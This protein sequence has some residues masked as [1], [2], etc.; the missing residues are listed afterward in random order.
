MKRQ[1]ITTFEQAEQYLNDTPKFTSKHTI[2]ETKEFLEKMG[3]PD[4]NM[5]IIHIAGTNGKGSTS[6]YLDSVLREAGLSTAL[7]TSP[8]LVDICERFCVNGKMM[9]HEEFLESFNH[10]Y[11]ML[12]WET[13]EKD[14]GYHPSYFEFLFFIAMDYF[15]KANV[16]WCILETGL[17]GMLDATNSV[18]KKEVAVITRIGL[19]HMEYLGDTIEEIAGQKA[20]II[21][22]GT[23][24]VYNDYVSEASEIIKK[25]FDEKNSEKIPS[26]Y[27]V[28]PNILLF[29]EFS[30][31]T[32]AFSLCDGY[33]K[34]VSVCLATS[35]TYQTEN[36]S[37]AIR[38][39]EALG[40][41][42]TVTHEMLANGLKKCHWAGRMEEIIPNVFI[43]G[44]HNPD[45]IR[46]FLETV[47]RDGF[48][49]SKR[50]LLFGVVAD[51]NYVG[52]IEELIDAQVFG[53]IVITSLH[54]KRSA[55]ISQLQSALDSVADCYE[56]VT[57]RIADNPESGL[58][59]MIS[60]RDNTVD[61]RIYVAG[62]LYLVGE[63]KKA[64]MDD[65]TAC[66]I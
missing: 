28:G 23:P 44:A 36:A 12:D 55:D 63:I 48:D 32:V 1:T 15:A 6:A 14:D 51:K 3:S 62:S 50:S 66:L 43:D 64:F 41:C 49:K 26:C 30:H 22:E 57:V 21:R 47:S 17:G 18:H 13:L 38:T 46:A 5:K 4:M 42:D 31:E 58:R 24:L 25:V 60:R 8:H 56:S 40:L 19:D 34:D 27:A 16:E 11:N 39:I 35:A 29:C 20:G 45:G 54:T 59:E 2:K 37:L 65:A 52:M 7:F 33:Y 61:N 53:E 9:S 10:I